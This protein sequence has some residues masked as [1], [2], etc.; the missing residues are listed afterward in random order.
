METFWEEN[1]MMA[2]MRSL[3]HLHS[4]PF[5]FSAIYIRHNTGM[6]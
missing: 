3:F 4:T 1:G 5:S 2:A 6:L